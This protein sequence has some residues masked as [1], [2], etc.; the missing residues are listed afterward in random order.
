ML[1]TVKK[2]VKFYAMDITSLRYS[3]CIY[4]GT[5]Y[6]I[7]VLFPVMRSMDILDWFRDDDT[8]DL[9]WDYHPVTPF[10]LI[11]LL[12]LRND[13]VYTKDIVNHLTIRYNGWYA[14][15]N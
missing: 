13:T 5:A 7:D 9:I 14:I 6:N 15:D 8:C 3:N 4:I 10:H 1:E 2:R 11:S 12:P